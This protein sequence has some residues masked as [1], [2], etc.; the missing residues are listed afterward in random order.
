M[1]VA[2]TEEGSATFLDLIADI[3]VGKTE[4]KGDGDALGRGEDGGGYLIDILKCGSR[5]RPHGQQQELDSK[6][7]DEDQDSSCTL[8][9]NVRIIPVEVVLKLEF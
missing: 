9:W 4:K 3:I 5:L 8:Y 1:P 2:Q 7:W 6:D